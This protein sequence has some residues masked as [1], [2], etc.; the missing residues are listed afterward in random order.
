MSWR[1]AAHRM[2]HESKE[3]CEALA[4][5]LGLAYSTLRGMA[6]VN[7]QTH[8]WSVVKLS[9]AM[10]LTGNREPLVELC[11]EHGGVFVRLEHLS[12]CTD[13]ELALVLARFGKELG[14]VFGEFNV[15]M[16]DGHLT[17]REFET[18][19]RQV[20]EAQEALA[21]LRERMA[22]RVEERALPRIVRG[23][24]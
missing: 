22:A 12:A 4:R 1:D 10:H 6:N 5:R 19:D 18:F 13:D 23:G 17:P 15:A 9:T 21:E 8:D 2:V 7:D 14:D 3:G 20:Y 24:K 11:R 16:A